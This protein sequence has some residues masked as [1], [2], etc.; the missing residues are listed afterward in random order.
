M[1]NRWFYCF[2]QNFCKE[3]RQKCHVEQASGEVE[4]QLCRVNQSAFTA[5]CVDFLRCTDIFY[6]IILYVVR[7]VVTGKMRNL[8][9]SLEKVTLCAEKSF[10]KVAISTKTRLKN[11]KFAKSPLKKS[12]GCKIRLK[13]H[14]PFF[15]LC[16]IVFCF[17]ENNRLIKKLFLPC[18]G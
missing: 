2:Q 3:L 17:Y 10:E 6:Y 15:C 18:A 8:Q 1:V 12:N 5:F 7:E 4:F 9:K 14:L 13:N 11:A 16:F